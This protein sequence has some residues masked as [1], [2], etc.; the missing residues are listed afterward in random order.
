M[1]GQGADPAPMTPAEFG[2][3]IA[4]DR[5]TFAQVIRAG[6]IRPD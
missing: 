2:A 6:N 5:A 4:R 3:R 1:A